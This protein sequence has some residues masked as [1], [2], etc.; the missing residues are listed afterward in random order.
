MKVE[1]L[2]NRSDRDG[3]FRFLRGVNENWNLFV[4]VMLGFENKPASANEVAEAL[5]GD[6]PTSDWHF[7]VYFRSDEDA[8]WFKMKYC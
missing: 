8:L 1:K 4:K 5:T 6:G 7:D 3:Y 2:G